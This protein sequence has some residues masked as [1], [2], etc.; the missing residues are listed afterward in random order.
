M[1]KKQFTLPVKCYLCSR[2]I[3]IEQLDVTNG[4]SIQCPHCLNSFEYEKTCA[5]VD[6]RN[7]AIIIHEDGWNPHSTSSAHSI[8]AITVSFGC[9]SKANRSNASNAMVY[10]FVPVHMLPHDAP[11]KYDALRKC[12]LLVHVWLEGEFPTL[13]VIPHFVTAD[14]K[15]HSEIGL[16]N[17]RGYRGCC[18]CFLGGTYILEKK[19][20][21]YYGNFRY[22]YR[23][24]VE[25]RTAVLN[26]Q[27]GSNVDSATSVTERK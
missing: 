12:T 15:A 6:P 2:I 4:T 26:R 3:P 18:C 10:S 1:K 25:S 17:T 21:Y 13:M 19:K 5:Y 27:Y 23:Y 22:R 11:H 8:S 16:T 20:H 9:M 14:S 24:P 7:Q